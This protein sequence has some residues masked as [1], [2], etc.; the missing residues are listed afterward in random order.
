MER[1][2]AT[3]SLTLLV[4][5]TFSADALA[6]ASHHHR[7][8]V[9]HSLRPATHTGFVHRSIGHASTMD[10][11]DLRQPDVQLTPVFVP[12]KGMLGQPCNLPTSA[13]PNEMRDGG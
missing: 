12:G 11:F 7:A 6:G 9:R 2:I 4:S 1:L 10:A 13:C 8:A 5:L 3:I